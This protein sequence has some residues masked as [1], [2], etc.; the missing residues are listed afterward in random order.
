MDINKDGK[1][2]WFVIH[3]LA[4]NGGNKVYFEW[5]MT[6][7]VDHFGCEICKPHIIKFMTN[8]PFK[9]Y[10]SIFYKNEEIGYFKWT[11]ELHNEVNKRLNKPIISLDDALILYKN[12]ICKNCDKILIP[13]ESDLPTRSPIKSESFNLIS[14]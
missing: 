12:M 7:L 10:N 3:T 1:G 9:N 6:T 11:W 13:I 5:M 14:R 2:I 4:L 8:H